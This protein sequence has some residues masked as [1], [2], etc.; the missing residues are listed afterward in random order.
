MWTIQVANTIPTSYRAYGMVSCTGN[1]QLSA[2][3]TTKRKREEKTNTTKKQK[4]KWNVQINTHAKM[5]A[6]IEMPFESHRSKN[7]ICMQCEWD[8][9]MGDDDRKVCLK[10][11]VLRLH[12]CNI[13]ISTIRVVCVHYNFKERACDSTSSH[14]TSPLICCNFSPFRSS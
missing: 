8:G 7:N 12:I 1:G 13:F 3:W 11:N 4:K 9:W 6:H 2:Y 5:C 10:C 14:C